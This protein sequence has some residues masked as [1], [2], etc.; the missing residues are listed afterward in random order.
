MTVK[1]GWAKTFW[2]K[3]VLMIRQLCPPYCQGGRVGKNILVQIS[4]ND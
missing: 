2:L 1:V 4:I 3:S